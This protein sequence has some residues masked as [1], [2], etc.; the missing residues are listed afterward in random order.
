MKR[1]TTYMLLKN[2]INN[3]PIKVKKIQ[4]KDLALDSRKV[5]AGC[6]FFA[7]KGTK[8]NGSKFIERAIKKGARA[9]IC[10]DKVKFKEKFIPIIKVKNVRETLSIACCKFFKKKPKNIIA[11]TGTNGKSSVANFFHQILLTNKKSVA[12]IGTLGIKK[13][14][15]IFSSKLTS[16]DIISLHRE[17]ENIKKNKINNVILEASSHGLHQ[18]RLD[19]LNFK[20]G[21]FTNLSQDHLDYHG[22]MQKYFEAKKLLFSKLLKKNKYIITDPNN[23]E[24][25]TLQKIAKKKKLKILSINNSLEVLKNTSNK[26]IGSFQTKNISM[27]VLASKLCGLSLKK[28]NSNLHKIK[29]VN[30][31]LELIRTLPNKSEVFIDYA[32]TPEALNIAVLSLKKHYNKEVTL[33]FGCGGERDVKKRPLM[34]KVAKKLCKKIYVTDDN[35]RNESPKRIRKTIIKYLKNK[36]Y[37]EI[38]NRAKA[39]KLALSN[40]EPAEIILIAGKGHETTQDYG[41]KVINTS[42]KQIINK[43]KF[44]NLFLNKKTLNNY[45]NSK[46]LKKVLNN[47]KKY[48]YQGVSINSKEIKKGNLFIAIKGHRNDG[49][50]YVEDALKNGANYCVISKKNKFKGRKKMISFENTFDFLKKLAKQKRITSDAKIIAITGS[51]GKTSVKNILGQLLKAYGDTYFSPGS[52]NN[53]YGVPLSLCNLEKNFKY[54]VLEIGMSKPGEIDKLS[55]LVSPDIGII[56]NIA[57]AH[58]ENFKNLKGIAKAKSEIIR[59]IKPGG[60]IILNHD[61]R[62]FY[63]LNGLAKKSNIKVTSFGKNIQSDIQLISIKKRNYKTFAS[64]KLFDRKVKIIL[65]NLNI[66]NVLSSIAVIKILGLDISKILEILKYLKPSEGR[67]RIYT[68]QRYNTNFKLIDESYN[69]NPLSVKNALYN[70]SE[71]EKNKSKKYV[72]LGDMLELGNKSKLYHKN[73]SKVINNADIDKIFVYGDKILNT[74]KYTKKI[75][76]GSILKNKKD[77]DKIFSKLIK[78]DDYLMIK[79]SNATGLNKFSNIIIKGKRNA[80]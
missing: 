23:K 11:V 25:T 49:H 14:H 75:K 70:L 20:A 64:V 51:A 69:A 80:I 50:D 76:Q 40:S 2:L 7:L 46:D 8:L 42:D 31:R 63:Y 12:S 9:I 66:Y 52:F 54:G 65:S 34:S 17:L 60:H 68:V 78:K 72:L 27:A 38:K 21:V 15:R 58:I 45:Y 1:F 71:I 6:L 24:F 43:I 28:I 57:E 37:I 22:T 26:I 36:N 56:T 13:N 55:K 18:G 16:P 41:N 77:F 53:H 73:L 44:K 33:V 10:N 47:K 30:G 61:D 3:C 74:F 62:F 48:K 67:G 79:G 4:I 5:K 59:N 29:P 32:H 35:P 39:I 19:G